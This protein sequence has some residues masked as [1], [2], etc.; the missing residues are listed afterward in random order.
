[1]DELIEEESPNT[2]KLDITDQ[3]EYFASQATEID[4]DVEMVDAD[5]V[6]QTI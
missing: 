3:R 4:N 6:S 1:M 2:H 5:Q